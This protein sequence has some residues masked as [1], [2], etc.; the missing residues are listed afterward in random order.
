MRREQAPHLTPTG[1][2]VVH[3][4]LPTLISQDGGLH[5]PHSIRKFPGYVDPEEKGGEPQY[6]TAAH[7]ERIMGAH[8]SEYMSMLEEEDQERY[9]IQFAKFLE[10]DLEADSLEDM[11]K[12]C[13]SKIRENPVF[14]KVE[15]KEV[16][17]EVLGNN[18]KTTID[19]EENE[20]VRQRRLSKAQRKGRVAQKI[21]AAQRKML[22]AMEADD[23]EE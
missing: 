9:K 11:Y 17:H 15:A 7:L 13:H 21:A 4:L 18:T 6:D 22:A 14:E 12:E 1:I 8:V 5:V 2:P 19:G 3:E 16:K 20:Y 23:D 10:N